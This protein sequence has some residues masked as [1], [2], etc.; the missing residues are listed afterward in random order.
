MIAVGTAVSVSAIQAMSQPAQ[1]QPTPC[2]M[3]PV[4]AAD[5][6][7]YQCGPN[8]YQKSYANGE[9]VYVVVAPPPGY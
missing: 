3:T 9:L 6:T 8:W 7:Y 5:A 4:T 1:D 2:A